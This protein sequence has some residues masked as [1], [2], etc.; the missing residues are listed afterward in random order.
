ME[1]SD[2]NGSFANAMPVAYF[3]DSLLG[4][5]DTKEINPGWTCGRDG[6]LCGKKAENRRKKRLKREMKWKQ[7]EMLQ[8]RE[9]KSYHAGTSSYWDGKGKVLTLFQRGGMSNRLMKKLLKSSVC[10]HYK[11]PTIVFK[12]MFGWRE[13]WKEGESPSIVGWK[14][15]G[16]ERRGEVEGGSLP[17]IP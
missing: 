1:E 10:L 17:P 9:L 13:R 12:G 3:E 5:Y 8:P 15:E 16:R 11:L 14:E 6:E 7:T 4:S 2:A